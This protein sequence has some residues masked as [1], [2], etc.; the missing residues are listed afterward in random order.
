MMSSIN[1]VTEK[2]SAF[3][4]EITLGMRFGTAFI[5]FALASR[6][7]TKRLRRWRR[8]RDEIGAR[9]GKAPGGPNQ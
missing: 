2:I 5:G 8:H 9:T 3:L 7:A 4:P 1:A 6:S